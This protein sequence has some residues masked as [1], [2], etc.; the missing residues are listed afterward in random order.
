MLVALYPHA[1]TEYKEIPLLPE[2]TGSMKNLLA[3]IAQDAG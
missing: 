3:N 1:T 2:E